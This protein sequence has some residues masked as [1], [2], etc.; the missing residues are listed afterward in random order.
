MK[1]TTNFTSSQFVIAKQPIFN[2]CLIFIFLLFSSYSFAQES[3]TVKGKVLDELNSPLN[4]VNVVLKN[5]DEG[6]VTDIDGNFEFLKPLQLND[7]LVFSYLGYEP[8]EYKIQSQNE[9]E[10]NITIQFEVSDVILMGAI[11][12]DELFS[13]TKSKQN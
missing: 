12:T 4:G 7:V 5:S 13:S 6:V 10:L 2:T 1:T 8:K 11:S 9:K 3:Y